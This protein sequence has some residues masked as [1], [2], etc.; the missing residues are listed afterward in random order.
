MAKRSATSVMTAQVPKIPRMAPQLTQVYR[1]DI[2][3]HETAAL[4]KVCLYMDTETTQSHTLSNLLPAA[5][6]L[7]ITTLLQAC[8]N[9][10]TLRAPTPITAFSYPRPVYF[11][12]G[13]ET[14]DVGYWLTRLENEPESLEQ[15]AA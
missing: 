10:S 14:F 2:L 8:D 5:L 12:T 6:L 15:R 13:D 7:T 1:P 11:L 9:S 3:F 4:Q